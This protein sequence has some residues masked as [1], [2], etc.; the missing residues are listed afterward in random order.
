M[1]LR[2]GDFLEG[3]IVENI[4]SE[5]NDPSNA[6]LLAKKHLT[7]AAAAGF[8]L[9]DMELDEDTVEDYLRNILVHVGEPGMPGD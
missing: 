7:E 1:T 8:T 3:W 2:G 9:A 4:T 5:A 6:G